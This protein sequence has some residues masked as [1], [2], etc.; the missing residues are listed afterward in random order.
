M[1]MCVW[2]PETC[3]GAEEQLDEGT[4]DGTERA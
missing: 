1:Y 4:E 3:E 2:D